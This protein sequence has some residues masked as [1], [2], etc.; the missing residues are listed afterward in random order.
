MSLLSYVG[1]ILLLRMYRE[2]HVCEVE[3]LVDY[4]IRDY[5]YKGR[6]VMG[7][8]ST[9]TSFDTIGQGLTS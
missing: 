5:L 4:N 2:R 6:L 8:S 9:L 1:L 7:Q 3:A